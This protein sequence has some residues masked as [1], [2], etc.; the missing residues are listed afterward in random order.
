MNVYQ[1]GGL[2]SCLECIT[3]V[4][5]GVIGAVAECHHQ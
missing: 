2:Y 3:M 5:M 4:V 1:N